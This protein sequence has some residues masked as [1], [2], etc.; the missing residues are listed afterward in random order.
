[1]LAVVVSPHRFTTA[2]TS[3]ASIVPGASYR[4]ITP[5]ACPGRVLGAEP[6]VR[7]RCLRLP[8]LVRQL[9][10]ALPLPNCTCSLS[11][12]TA[13]TESPT[14]FRWIWV[15][16]QIRKAQSIV[17]SAMGLLMAFGTD[18]K[19]F[20]IE[21]SENG[22]D[23][24]GFFSTNFANMAGMVHFHLLGAVADTAWHSQFLA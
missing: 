5:T 15:V 16:C 21:G 23:A 1:M 14:L 13:L 10:V 6:Q 20:S 8:Q 11:L 2:L 17:L 22:I 7:C 3:E 9:R 18:R 4:R 19:L 24:N 12:H